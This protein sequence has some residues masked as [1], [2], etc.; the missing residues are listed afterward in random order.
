VE[1]VF[2]LAKTANNDPEHLR[3]AYGQIDWGEVQQVIRTENAK[4]A[5]EIIEHARLRLGLYIGPSASR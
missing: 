2:S 3:K 4:A 5:D 1:N